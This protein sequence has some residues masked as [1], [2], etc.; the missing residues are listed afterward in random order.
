M[1]LVS[2]LNN[3]QESFGVLGNSGLHPVLEAFKKKCPDL[4]SVIG[5][6]KIE[7]LEK[8]CEENSLPLSQVNLLPPISKPGKIICAGMNYRKPYPV[9]RIAPPDPGNIVIFSRHSDTLVGDGTKLEYPR[10]E[11]AETFDFEG[12][13]VAVIGKPGRFIS[14]EDALQHVIGYSIM[15]EGSVRGWMKHSVH[16][17]KNFHASGSWGPWITTVDEIDDFSSLKLETHVNGKLMQSASAAELIFS[18]SELIAYISNL[19]PLNPGD[20]IA[21]GSPDGTGGSRNP[22]VFLKPGDCVEVSVDRIGTLK[23]HVGH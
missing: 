8:S 10:G 6:Q 4:K 7:A 22:S 5:S 16:A 2:F 20:I 14:S 23:N 1:K 17:G 13:I 19:T 12:E 9:D 18:L 15:N 21:T 3:G 11:A